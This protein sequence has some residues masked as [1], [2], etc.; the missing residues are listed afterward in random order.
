MSNV[1]QTARQSSAAPMTTM[2]ALADGHVPSAQVLCAEE[3]ET[4]RVPSRHCISAPF[5]VDSAEPHF[6]SLPINPQIL[7][8]PGPAH[9]SIPGWGS[10]V[11]PLQPTCPSS[12]PRPW[13]GTPFSTTLRKHGLRNL[14]PGS[15]ACS[16]CAVGPP[17]RFLV[18]SAL[19]FGGPSGEG[20]IRSDISVNLP[21]C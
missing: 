10:D 20:D 11:L 18:L 17:H 15:A 1:T 14:S 7:P 6:C 19:R 16:L 5:H 3:Q 12:S 13:S 4:P 8:S 2:E 9:T 21:S